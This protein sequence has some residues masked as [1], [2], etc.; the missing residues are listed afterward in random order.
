MAALV[1]F[2]MGGLF[3]FAYPVAVGKWFSGGPILGLIV[4]ESLAFGGLGVLFG[5][6]KGNFGVKR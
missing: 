6:F 1:C 3:V 4:G 5:F 2:V